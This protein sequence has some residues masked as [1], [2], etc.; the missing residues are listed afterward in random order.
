MEGHSEEGWQTNVAGLRIDWIE[1]G[2]VD[3]VGVR[4][5]LLGWEILSEYD[6]EICCAPELYDDEMVDRDMEDVVTGTMCNSAGPV[7][8]GRIA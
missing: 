3:T 5:M 8:G 6:R 4:E 7:V 1:F 2:R